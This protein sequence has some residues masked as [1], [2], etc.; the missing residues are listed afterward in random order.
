MWVFLHLKNKNSYVKYVANTKLSDFKISNK[1]F[2]S[3]T[4]KLFYIYVV[5]TTALLVENSFVIIGSILL[6]FIIFFQTEIQPV[7]SGYFQYFLFA[8]VILSAV[9]SNLGSSASD[10]VIERDWIVVLSG[11]DAKELAS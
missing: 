8:L 2:K 10:I 11:G 5:A 7:W 9:I 3:G 6:A 4:L 1:V